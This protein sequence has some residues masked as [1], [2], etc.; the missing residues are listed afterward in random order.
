MATDSLFGASKADIALATTIGVFILMGGIIGA[1][2]INCYH[3]PDVTCPVF[4][5]EHFNHIVNLFLVLIGA[6]AIYV[7]FK[8]YNSRTP[9]GAPPTGYAVIPAGGTPFGGTT[10]GQSGTPS[11]GT[12]VNPQVPGSSVTSP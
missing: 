12:N 7:G 10:G 5:Q 4:T 6:G 11:T 8:I 1:T 9:N 2:Y 3:D